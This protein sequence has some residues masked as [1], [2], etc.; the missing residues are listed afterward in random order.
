MF[1]VLQLKVKFTLQ[2]LMI[3]D[4]LAYPVTLKAQGVTT[5]TS[6]GCRFIS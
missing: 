3:I 1:A 2:L 6:E 4:I 5:K